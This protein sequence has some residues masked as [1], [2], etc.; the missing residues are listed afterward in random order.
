MTY[1]CMDVINAVR[2]ELELCVA[3]CI[4][5]F[6]RCMIVSDGYHVPKVDTGMTPIG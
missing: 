6:H 4:Q 3:L 1:E 2:N 5:I